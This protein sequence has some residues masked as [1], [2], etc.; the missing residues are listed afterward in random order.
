MSRTFPNIL[1]K[2][3]V[4]T[5]VDEHAETL[6]GGTGRS[7]GSAARFIR[8]HS[9][10]IAAALLLVIGSG[11][12]RLGGDYWLSKHTVSASTASI[13]RLP[14]KP[15]AGFNTTVPAAELQNR[16][17]AI[18]HQP[19]TL[20]VGSLD[21]LVDSDTIKSWLQITA[22][23]D[24]TEYYVHVNGSAIGASLTKQA[25][26]YVQSPVDQVTVTEDGVKRVVV[27]GQ[28][29]TSLSDP[30]T[31]K[32]QAAQTAKNVLDAKGLKFSTP[33]ATR[34][35]RAVTPAD[36][37]K[38]IVSDITKKK[39][40]AWQ[41]GKQVNSWLVSAGKPTTPT[42]LGSFKIYAKFTVQ[43]MRGNNPDGSPYFQ[44]HVRWV[45][46]FSDGSAIHG[47]YWHPL[48]WFGAINSSHGCIGVPDDEA[49]W[50]FNWAPIGTPVIVHA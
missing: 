8:R 17:R 50:I 3:A 38:I 22:N 6:P 21:T 35:F 32:T 2:A 18:T 9:V 16:I 4:L 36:F 26:R 19:I 40:W 48:S 31:L 20:T 25:G 41:N 47:V 1:A 7:L 10:I 5:P 24:K 45:N 34:P 37:D 23:K 30:G 46:Y 11:A 39:M 43:D 33:L 13:T 27:A 29:G 42:P 12:I 28:N 14:A 15:I 44:P 49:E